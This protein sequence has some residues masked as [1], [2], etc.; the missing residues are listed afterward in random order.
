MQMNPELFIFLINSAIRVG[1]A[2]GNAL[3]QHVRDAEALFPE[4]VKVGM[5]RSDF[6]SEFFKSEPRYLKLVEGE[7]APFAAYWSTDFHVVKSKPEAVETLYV[8]AMKYISERRDI[9]RVVDRESFVGA[10]MV[11]QWAEGQGPVSPWVKVALAVAD[12]AFNYVGTDSSRLGLDGNGGKLL[13][14]F[15]LELSNLLPDDDQLGQKQDFIERLSGLFIQAGLRTL[16]ENSGLVIH[17][18]H[19]QELVTGSL[20][21]VIDELPSAET[22]LSEHINYKKAA[23]ALIGPA[24]NAAL[25]IVGQNQQAFFGKDLD[26]NQAIGALT[27]ALIEQGSKR[28]ID[29]VFTREGLIALY[30]A[31]LGVAVERPE[32]FL[33][34]ADTSVEATAKALFT[35]FADTLRKNPPPFDGQLGI[36]LTVTA[37]DTLKANAPALIDCGSSW[38][39]IVE[40]LVDQVVTGLKEGFRSPDSD[41]IQSALTAIELGDLAKVF[42]TQAARKPSIIAGDNQRLKRLV[43]GIAEGIRQDEAHL[44]TAEEWLEIAGDSALNT[45]ADDPA[46][47]L[48][49]DFRT[50]RAGGALLQAFLITTAEQKLREIVSK[51]SLLALYQSVLRVATDQPELFLGREPAGGD[52]KK[53]TALAAG[54]ELFSRV[55]RT[56][57]NNPPPFNG[58]LGIELIIT[59]L[60]TVNRHIPAL[61]SFDRN[62]D[63][64]IETL[65]DQVIAGLIEGFQ[66]ASDSPLDSILTKKQLVDLMRVFIEQAA[67]NPSW[68]AGQNQDL[69][70]VVRSVAM[71]MAAD[72]NLLLGKDDWLEIA[73]VATTEAAV[74]PGRLFGLA[75]NNRDRA[76]SADLLKLL[77]MTAGDISRQPELKDSSVLHGST[78]RKG[79]NILIRAASGNPRAAEQ[80]LGLI[81]QYAMIISTFVS[82]N[83]AHSGSNE[84]LKLFHNLLPR[85][86]AGDAVEKAIPG[87]KLTA[88][89]AKEIIT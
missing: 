54:K 2:A 33:G 39:P 82:V 74:N 56:L 26:P 30:Q 8:L 86:L 20:K 5:K 21:P 32:L 69:Q 53:T 79:I 67:M 61:I 89:N 28:G 45:I 19:L 29:Q 78:L 9:N 1:S 83:S 14:A 10:V 55:A 7:K 38:E 24:A 64:L 50:D 47:F 23:E 59:M 58:D 77:L 72:G 62:W 63:Q 60:D 87:G 73:S 15:A 18:A 70:R 71:A 37:L 35:A 44:L 76:L 16:H 75:H 6:V 11:K 80:N 27:R 31:A 65:V 57:Q 43:K 12:V 22:A 36:E 13:S 4:A 52:E 25:M 68:I 85:A 41:P 49:A 42:V 66:T 34:V 48:G 46:D 88:T 81:K 51:K 84:W 3:A 40:K 17:A